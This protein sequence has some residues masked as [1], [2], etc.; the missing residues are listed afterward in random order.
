MEDIDILT[1]VRLW[2]EDERFS[3]QADVII[4]S[5]SRAIVADYKTGRGEVDPAG[6]NYQMATLANLV[7]RNYGVSE[8]VVVILQPKALDAPRKTVAYYDGKGLDKLE[9]G[10]K[11]GITEALSDN[12]D[13]KICAG[14]YC[15]YCPSAYRC[16]VLQEKSKDIVHNAGSD[17]V[18]D[19]T[20]AKSFFEN[21]KLV[22]KHCEAILQQV[23]AFVAKHGVEDTGLEYK[24]GNK[25]R[26]GLSCL[27]I[28][29]SMNDN[30]PMNGS[31]Y[32]EFIEKCGSISIPKVFNFIKENIGS[33]EYQKSMENSFVDDLL[34]RE[35]IKI[36]QSKPTLK[37]KK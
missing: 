4:K 21:A 12:I 6:V 3:G 30:F 23:A 27:G 15:K 10:I 36:K 8:V 1:E 28:Y 19:K 7:R 14:K 35:Y 34:N 16:P 33:E 24:D 31:T 20:N 26:E 37:I 13:K 17:A 25:I 29:E 5:N 9:K 11:K 18:I 22:Q 32:N 2:S